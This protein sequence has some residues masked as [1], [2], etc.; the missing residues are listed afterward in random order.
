MCFLRVFAAFRASFF[1]LLCDSFLRRLG[2]KYDFFL[3]IIIVF[4]FSFSISIVFHSCFSSLFSSL[5]VIR[6]CGRCARIGRIRL[7]Q[8]AQQSIK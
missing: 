7:A 2:R 6:A 3:R 1:V 8:V 5:P 4:S